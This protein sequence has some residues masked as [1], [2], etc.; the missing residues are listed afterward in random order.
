VIL[1]GYHKLSFFTNEVVNVNAA[2]K[3]G[4]SKLYSI[5]L[6][7]INAGD[8]NRVYTFGYGMGTEIN[9]NPKK[10]LSINPELSAQYLYLGS[11]DYTNIV[12]RLN[13]NVNIK[14]GKYFSL[15]TGP[16]Y[17]VYISDQKTGISGYRFPVPPPG[18]NT[19]KYS[20]KVTGWFGWNAGINIF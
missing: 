2:F 11:W 9:L 8:S 14:L 7:G 10:T 17:T 5:L 15:F 3:T 4:N 18:Y 19:H 1:K 13:L 6:A 16:S 12:N 20:D